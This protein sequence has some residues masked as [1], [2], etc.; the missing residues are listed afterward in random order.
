MN[1]YNFKKLNN[2]QKW[3]EKDNAW[4]KNDP[5]EYVRLLIVNDDVELLKKFEATNNTISYNTK[6]GIFLTLAMQKNAFATVDYL[7]EKNI[8]IKQRDVEALVKNFRENTHK[9]NFFALLS[10]IDFNK[11]DLSAVFN[12]L[13]YY[14]D[15]EGTT[16]F[17]EYLLDNKIHIDDKDTEK[18]KQNDNLHFL[19]KKQ[20]KEKEYKAMSEK[21]VNKN[22]KQ[23]N[24]KI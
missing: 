11:I 14:L 10:K 13:E 6:D 9:D 24:T 15:D 7:L 23:K 8:Q 1:N 3:Q 4:V 20:E 2:E 12:E 16:A 22:I 21:L 5:E 17:V 18:L 19:F